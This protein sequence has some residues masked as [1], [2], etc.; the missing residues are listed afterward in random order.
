MR[1]EETKVTY[2]IASF[3]IRQFTKDSVYHDKNRDSRKN[4]KIIADIIKDKEIDIIAI[5]EIRHKN[6]LKELISALANGY[7]KD[8]TIEMLEQPGIDGTS[9]LKSENMGADYLACYAGKWQGRWTHPNSKWGTAI[10]EEGY[11]FVWNS[12]KFDLAYNSKG[13]VQPVIKHK[14]ETYF[15]RPP[16][17]GRFITKNIGP[18][19]EIGILNTHVLYTTNAKLKKF[20]ELGIDIDALLSDE[21]KTRMDIMMEL[22]KAGLKPIEIEVAMNYLKLND[23]DRRR[24]E[25]H[26]L[27]SEVLADEE[28]RR[29]FGSYLFMMGDYNLNLANSNSNCISKRASIDDRIILWPEKRN[30]IKEYMLTQDKLTTLKIPPRK[31]EEAIK[32]Y[33]NLKDEDRFANNYDHFTYNVNMTQKDGRD[34]YISESKRINVLDDYGLMNN[35]YFQTI[36]DHLPIMI[37]IGF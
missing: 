10:S 23:V 7:C 20:K 32:K 16:F 3:N 25:V 28:D 1:K 14:K 31:D 12:D 5:Q 29:G 24:R 37:E 34:I 9:K 35:E 15:V 17:Y 4:L 13:K 30:E 36:S 6:A 19:F 21:K 33:A 2:R 11:A 8:I 26:N 18:E 27:V 22:R